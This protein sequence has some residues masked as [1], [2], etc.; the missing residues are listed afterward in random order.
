MHKVLDYRLD[1]IVMNHIHHA[2][3]VFFFLAAPSAP[4]S[5]VSTTSTSTTITVLWGAVDCI[6]R[7]GNIT[8]YTIQYG[9]VGS[10]NTHFVSVSGGASTEDTVSGL[11]PST[12]YSIHVAAVNSA[13]IGA[14]SVDLTVH[15]AG[16]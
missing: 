14:H 10:G 15:T 11:M 16:S 9:V 4:P 5:S 12:A 8:G 3:A 13:G 2:C 1:D 7:N 6:H